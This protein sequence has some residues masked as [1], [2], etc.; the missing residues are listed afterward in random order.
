MQDFIP[1]RWKQIFYVAKM[2]STRLEAMFVLAV[3]KQSMTA[4]YQKFWTKYGTMTASGVVNVQF[5]WNRNVFHAITSYIVKKTSTGEYCESG[6]QLCILNLE[7]KAWV[8]QFTIK[9]AW[10]TDK[11]QSQFWVSKTRQ[12]HFLKLFWFLIRWKKRVQSIKQIFQ[13]IIEAINAFK[14]VPEIKK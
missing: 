1:Q 14:W 2:K 13:W 8:D 4:F 11:K 6:Y 9:I 5:H 10:S 3:N 7:P 12:L